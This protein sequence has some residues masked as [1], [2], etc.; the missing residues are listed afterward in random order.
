MH[1]SKI[2][3]HIMGNTRLQCSI[4]K[5]PL[6]IKTFRVY[7]YATVCYMRHIYLLNY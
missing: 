3:L 1:E 6:E 7:Q 4:I 5:V 2:T